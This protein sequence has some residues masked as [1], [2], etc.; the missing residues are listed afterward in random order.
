MSEQDLGTVKPE[1]IIW[2][3]MA[4]AVALSVATIL[5]F[6]VGAQ[7]SAALEGAERAGRFEY[8]HPSAPATK[9]VI[10]PPAPYKLDEGWLYRE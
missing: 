10:Y 6:S 2:T 7:V 5:A 3:L 9:D 8:T 4:T 1:H